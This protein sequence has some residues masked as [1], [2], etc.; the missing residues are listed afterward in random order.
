MLIGLGSSTEHA[1]S[2][3]FKRALWATCYMFVS[4]ESL[5]GSEQI[6]NS[7]LSSCYQSH[8]P[9]AVFFR[10]AQSQTPLWSLY[11]APLM[12][13][14]VAGSRGN[15][16]SF[17]FIFLFFIFLVFLGPNQQHMEILRLGVNLR[18]VAASICHSHSNTR[19]EMHSW[20]T[21]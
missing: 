7:W 11:S 9:K 3:N 16:Y 8:P 19:S 18:A 20:P 17:F 15:I 13:T 12:V 6:H 10:L 4:Q 14:V 5:F 2:F 21:P 1:A